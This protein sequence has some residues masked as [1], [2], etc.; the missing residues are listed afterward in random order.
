MPVWLSARGDGHTNHSETIRPMPS[1]L[2]PRLQLPCPL[3]PCPLVAYFAM[4]AC[5][6]TSRDERLWLMEMWLKRSKDMRRLL[7]CL[8]ATRS[9]T[10]DRRPLRR[11]APGRRNS[12]SAFDTSASGL[13][14]SAICAVE[15]AGCEVRT[16][17]FGRAQSGRVLSWFSSFLGQSTCRREKPHGQHC[18]SAQLRRQC[19]EIQT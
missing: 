12:A 2:Q 13:V 19:R 16:V 3:C 14:T 17:A 7:L 10:L 18:T 5:R 8:D 15:K 1:F 4:P 11:C 6:R 9:R